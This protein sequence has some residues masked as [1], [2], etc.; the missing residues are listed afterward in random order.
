MGFGVTLARQGQ[1]EQVSAEL[2]SG[3]FFQTLGVGA[4]LGRVLTPQDDGAP[5]G[6]PVVVLGHGYWSTKCGGNPAILNQT[7]TMNGHPVVVV[8]VA[9][10]RF[11]GLRPGN[12][13]VRA[14]STCSSPLAATLPSGGMGTAQRRFKLCDAIDVGRRRPSRPSRPR[15]AGIL[16]R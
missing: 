7:V 6:N 15:T 16:P 12:L 10:A 2:V 9:E 3:N 14:H 1:A 13:T 11:R 5:G 8:G 4:A